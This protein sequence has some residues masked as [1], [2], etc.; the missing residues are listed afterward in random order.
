METQ[1]DLRNSHIKVANGSD[2]KIIII[3]HYCFLFG[4]HLHLGSPGCGEGCS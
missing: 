3:I 4:L 2:V 1:V